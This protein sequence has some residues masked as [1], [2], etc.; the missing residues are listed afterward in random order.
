MRPDVWAP[1]V[2]LSAAERT[3]VTRIRRATLFVFLRL[4]RHELFAPDFQAELG[5]AYADG[6]RGRPPVPPARLALATLLQGD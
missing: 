5:A 6:P 4:W 2:A 3:I 1:P